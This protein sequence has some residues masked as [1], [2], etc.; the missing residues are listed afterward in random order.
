MKMD[1]LAATVVRNLEVRNLSATELVPGDIVVLE[2][3]DQVPADLRL[4][5]TVNLNIVE[6]ALTGESVAVEKSSKAIKDK[7]TTLGDRFGNAFMSTV[8]TKGRGKGVVVC[9]GK[10]TEIGRISKS[11]AAAQ[12]PKTPLQAKLDRLGKFLVV[13]SVVLCGVVVGIGIARGN[14]AMDMVKVGISLA[15]S[16]IPEGLVAVTTVTMAIGVRRMA[17]QNAIVRKLPAVEAL[18]SITTICSDK[19]G[20]LTIG[21]MRATSLWAGGVR[22][23]VSGGANGPD[24]VT[25]RTDAGVNVPHMDASVDAAAIGFEF[26]LDD[27]DREHATAVAGDGPAGMSRSLRM[28]LLACSLCNNAT[29]QQRKGATGSDDGWELLGDATEIA[30]A[31]VSHGMGLGKNVI[32]NSCGLSFAGEFAFDSDRKRMSVIYS[33]PGSSRRI[34]LA[35]GAPESV[36]SLCTRVN[37]SDGL[38]GTGTVPLQEARKDIETMGALLASDGLRVLGLGYRII[39]GDVDISDITQVEGD[40][41]FLGLLG[42]MD[43]PRA[44]V[45]DAIDECHRAGIKVAMITGD[46]PSTA[47]AIAVKLGIVP[48]P[49]ARALRGDEIDELHAAGRLEKLAPFPS[50]YARVSPENKL[51]IVSALQA[52]GEVVAMTGDGVNDAAAIRKSDCGVAMGITGTDVAKQ[53]ADIVLSDDSFATIALAI[54]EGRRVYDNIKKFIL[55]LLSC[56]TAEIL[57]MLIAVAAGA[58]I[59]FAAIQILYA[60]IIAD[61]PPAMVL[62]LDTADRNVMDRKPRDPKKGILTKRTSIILLSQ[63]LSMALI[64]YAALNIAYYAQD[65]PLDTTRTFTFATLTSV[66]LFHAFL[67]RSQTMSIFRLNPFSNLHL[68]AAVALSFALLIMGIY[69]PGFNS[70][71]DLVPLGAEDWGMIALAILVHVVLS[72]LLKLYLRRRSKRASARNTDKLFYNDL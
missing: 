46:H 26:I 38:D 47:V 29:V 56:N 60:N 51:S 7:K 55:Y 37:G 15:V 14:D 45:L 30:L 71:L 20:T 72:E 67:S 59:P 54:K 41:C 42:L 10:N 24:D 21:K 35:K 40:L 2:E 66:Q 63:G 4:L 16:V 28:A 5:E 64:A 44:E 9:T 53:A 58:P 13:V 69:I 34:V 49:G 43:P 36:V 33:I 39:D 6:A 52:N 32:T 23:N 11:I 62:G 19:T 25:V 48:D 65:K 1:V 68:V 22:Y 3:G 8:V 12:P 70:L 18:G 50:V 27:G 17:R 57:I 31:V 61:I